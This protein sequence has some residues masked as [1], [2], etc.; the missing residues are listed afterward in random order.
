MPLAAKIVLI[1]IGVLLLILALIGS[2]ISRRLMTIPK[3]HR[4]PRIVLAVLGVLLLAGGMWGLWTGTAKHSPTLDD[5]RAH[6]PADVKSALNCTE[7]SESPKNGVALDCSTQGGFP[8]HVYY[9]MF[10][11]VNSMQKYWIG[12]ANPS[13]LPGTQCNTTDDFEKGSKGT[14]SL[15]DQSITIGDVACS[16]DGNTAVVA[17][18][19][20]RFNMVIMADESD[21]QKF[22]DFINWVDKTSQPPGPTDTA[23]P[24]PSQTPGGS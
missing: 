10:P 11:D 2:G 12:K 4:A 17:Y 18:T 6:V 15:G 9:A 7:A 21:P 16:M 1:V 3:M 19:D 23:P 22:S 20:R 14:Y 8:D 24:T 5:L 13:N